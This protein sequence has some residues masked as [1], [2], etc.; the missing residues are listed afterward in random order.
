MIEYGP[1]G[2]VLRITMTRDGQSVTLSGYCRYWVTDDQMGG[3]GC[4]EHSYVGLVSYKWDSI[5]WVREQRIP[6]DIPILIGEWVSDEVW[7]AG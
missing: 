7:R 2:G 4:S 6:I 3:Y 1:E 5:R